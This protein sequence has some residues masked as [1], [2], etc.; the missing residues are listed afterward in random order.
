MALISS[1]HQGMNLRDPDTLK[2]PGETGESI[3]IDFSTPGI[4]RPMRQSSLVKTP[5]TNYPI[6]DATCVYVGVDKYYFTTHPDGLRVSYGVSDELHIDPSFTGTFKALSIN[7]DYVVLATKDRCVKWKPGWDEVETWGLNTPSRPNLSAGAVNTKWIETF[8]D[9]TGWS[10]SGGGVGAAIAIDAA[11]YVQGSG[12]LKLTCDAGNTI[13]TTKNLTTANLI[14]NPGFETAG[15]GAPDIHAD[16]TETAADGAIADDAAVFHGDAHALKITTGATTGGTGARSAQEASVIPNGTYTFQA[17]SYGD[18]TNAGRYKIYDVTNS[19]DIV[20]IT[21]TLQTAAA[22]AMVEVDITIPD[23]CFTISITLY[24]PSVNGGITRW[25]DV[26]LETNVMDLSKYETDGDLKNS[27][28]KLSYYTDNLDTVAAIRIK[29]SCA[30]NG[31]FDKDYYSYEVKLDG[32][33]SNVLR[34]V[35]GGVLKSDGW[36]LDYESSLSANTYEGGDALIARDSKD[37]FR[38][39]MVPYANEGDTIDPESGG[40]EIV[41]I[42]IVAPTNVT[43]SESGS[44][45]YLR[46]HIG[47]FVLNRHTTGRDWSTITGIQIELEAQP[48]TVTTSPAVV[49]F[50]EMEMVGGGLWGY[51]WAAVAFQNSFANYGPYSAF[52]G[53]QYLEGQDLIISDISIDSDTQ[54]VKRRIALLGGSITEPM[55]T[56]VDDNTTTTLTYNTLDSGLVEMETKFHNRPPTGCR[57]MVCVQGRIFMVGVPGY[58]GRVVY[59]DQLSFEAF[60][61]RNYLSVKEG[62]N[63]KQISSFGQ[64]IAVRGKQEYQISLTGTDPLYWSIP[65]GG[66]RFGSESSR[67][68][69]EI[70]SGIHIFSSVKGLYFSATSG[71]DGPYLPKVSNEISNPSAV[72]GGMAGNKAYLYFRDTS[73]TDRVMRIDFSLGSPVAHYVENILPVSIFPD[74]MSQKVYYALGDSIYEFDGY[75]TSPLPT[76]LEVPGQFFGSNKLKAFGAIDYHQLTGGP[77]NVTVTYDGVQAGDIVVLQNS[78]DV[79]EPSSLPLGCGKSIGFLI[80]S[81]TEDYVLTLPLDLDGGDIA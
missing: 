40:G 43:K 30:S 11:K 46:I 15:A 41:E 66:A 6:V 2:E 55:V 56:Y 25:D 77:L 4:I 63:L 72:I 71:E 67:F 16:W 80:E 22:W 7:N 1:L 61:Y 74:P 59:S 10:T 29:L 81:T 58:A 50:D 42:P 37:P 78:G 12:S 33:K 68:L 17:W 44:W 62:E 18:G 8:E 35:D 20:E 39:S 60:P 38:K 53:P 21:S 19:E 3:G 73:G 31:G 23:D 13:I 48:E 45:T 79:S 75:G 26:S 14:S 64:N 34:E 32:K 9:V 70:E 36:G 27:F 5:K 54:T 28:I 52:Q 76:T 49:S 51:Y 57:D 65:P 69:L 24:G 47:S